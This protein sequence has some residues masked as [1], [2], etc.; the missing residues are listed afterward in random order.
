MRLKKAGGLE[1]ERVA[2]FDELFKGD[3]SFVDK[4]LA[5]KMMPRMTRAKSRANARAAAA[6]DGEDCDA[7]GGATAAGAATMTAFASD[8]P[9]LSRK[10]QIR[11]H[12]AGGPQY[13]LGVA[14]IWTMVISLFG[15]IAQ[16]ALRAG[17]PTAGN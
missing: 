16:A 6:D 11:P 8:D 2:R 14:G 3:E 9:E 13:Y 17:G 12:T 1:E 4:L 15:A 7:A 10:V 5:G